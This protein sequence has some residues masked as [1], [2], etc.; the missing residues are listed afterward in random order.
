MLRQ[1]RHPQ[2]NMWLTVSYNLAFIK[3][4]EKFS[5]DFRMY[6]YT[7]S[8]LVTENQSFYSNSMYSFGLQNQ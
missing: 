3:L 2:L 8:R 7:V 1:H 4:Y 6:L 5:R